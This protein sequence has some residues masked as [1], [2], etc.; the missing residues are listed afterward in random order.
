MP[1]LGFGAGPVLL[2]YLRFRWDGGHLFRP[3]DFPSQS[4]ETWK[5]K[6]VALIGFYMR[7][8]LCSIFVFIC[9]HTFG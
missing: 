4:A 6:L 7:I 2:G 1:L 8:C 9:A 3:C 5:V